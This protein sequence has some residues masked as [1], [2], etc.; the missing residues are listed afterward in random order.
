MSLT[1]NENSGIFII[2]APYFFSTV[3]GWIK[4]WFDP[5]TVSKIF[6][7]SHSEIIPVLSQFMEMKDI[8]KVYGG[9]LPWEYFDEPLWDDGIMNLCQWED[10]YTCFPP[11]PKKWVPID[12]GKRLECIA[13]GYKDGEPRHDRVC[14]IPNIKATFNS[15]NGTASTL[16]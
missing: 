8:P 7:L 16:R 11:G 6:I 14:T 4:K 3:W 10:G 1:S 15:V 12:D 9:E 2:G 13:I 5:V